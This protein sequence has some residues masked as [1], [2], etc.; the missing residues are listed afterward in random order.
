[1]YLLSLVKRI[2]MII[3]IKTILL[4]RLSKKEPDLHH[5]AHAF[6]VMLLKCFEIFLGIKDLQTLPKCYGICRNFI[7]KVWYCK[8]S[9]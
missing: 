3:S 5:V 9:T 1:M 2:K 6:Q 8:F 7:S 4:L